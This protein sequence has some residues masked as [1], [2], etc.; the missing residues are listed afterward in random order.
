VLNGGGNVVELS[1]R[2]VLANGQEH[3]VLIIRLS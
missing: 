1:M 3:A 2:V